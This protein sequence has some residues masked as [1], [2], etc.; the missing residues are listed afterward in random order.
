MPSP[1]TAQVT[2]NYPHEKGHL[3]PRFRGEHALRRYPNGKSQCKQ[4]CRRSSS[5]SRKS[6][7]GAGAPSTAIFSHANVGTQPAILSSDEG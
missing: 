1:A 3:S 7:A 4:T 2:I 6:E 5:V